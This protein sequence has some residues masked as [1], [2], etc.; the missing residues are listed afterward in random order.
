MDR[1]P[2][3]GTASELQT[4]LRQAV[5]HIRRL[6]KEKQQLIEVGNRLRAQL[7]GTVPMSTTSGPGAPINVVKAPSSLQQSSMQYKSGG[8]GRLEL[9]GKINNKLQELEKMQYRLT[10]QQLS[11]KQKTVVGEVS[12]PDEHDFTTATSDEDMP[13]SIL[14]KPSS[15]VLA[16]SGG[17]GNFKGTLE[18]SVP[19]KDSVEFS[20]ASLGTTEYSIASK[21]RLEF[22]APTR[23]G[24]E[25]S[26]PTK[27]TLEQ[28]TGMA[29]SGLRHSLSSTG[30]T[31]LQEVWQLLDQA[32]NY[33]SG[34]PTPRQ[35]SGDVAQTSSL[36]AGI[37]GQA[38]VMIERPKAKTPPPAPL[39]S[40]RPKSSQRGKARGRFAARNWNVK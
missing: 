8:V 25:Y 21:D 28:S 1:L 10:R 23:D 24:M 40:Q 12:H 19:I 14:K 22:S 13:K 31:S 26:A 4:K 35:P 2:I 3:K 15:P 7:A 29:G 18:Y 20:A 16:V 39:T 32:E 30:G 27:N 11:M 6:T 34:P 17:Y 5:K 37:K 9:Q 38:P 33:S 36:V